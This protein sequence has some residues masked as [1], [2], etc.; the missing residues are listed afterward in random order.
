M[1][2]GFSSYRGYDVVRTFEYREDLLGG[3]QESNDMMALQDV[4]R[5]AG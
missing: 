3:E 2:L 5:A 1:G 4:T